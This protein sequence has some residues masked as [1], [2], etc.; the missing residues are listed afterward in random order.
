MPDSRK[1]NKEQL[2]LRHARKEGALIMLV[3]AACLLWS[4]GSGYYLGYRPATEKLPL[5]LGMPAW[6]FWSVLLPWF[7]VLVFGGWFAFYY[8]ADDDLGQD[9]AEESTGRQV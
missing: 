8:M 1:R 5:I 9:P 6:V 7:I 3:W 4:V 2:L